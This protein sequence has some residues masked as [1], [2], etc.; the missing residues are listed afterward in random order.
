MTAAL[1]RDW[2]KAEMLFRLA[3]ESNHSNA[4]ALNWLAIVLLVPQLRFAEAVDAVFAAYDLDPASPEIGNEIVWVRI[5]CGQYGEAADQARRIVELHP[6]FVEACWSL[7]VAESASGN[8]VEARAAL[9]RADRAGGPMAMTAALRCFADG[10]RGDIE[11]ARGNLARL[12]GWEDASAVRAIFRA[13]AS[14]AIGD[15]EEG[16]R[17]LEQAVDDADPHAMYVEV[18]PPNARLR[19]HPRYPGILTRQ[20]LRRLSAAASREP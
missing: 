14:A 17:H 8:H 7:A 16:I 12:E 5:C 18:F 19:S 10:A 1:G 15:V 3:I 6:L 2:E 20:R 9:D 4:L 11:A 13:W